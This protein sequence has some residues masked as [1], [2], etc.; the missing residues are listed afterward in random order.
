VDE[1]GQQL[2]QHVGVAA[3]ESFGQHSGRSISW[4]VVIAC[5]PLLE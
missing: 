5:I 1:R 4:A 2:A 3:G